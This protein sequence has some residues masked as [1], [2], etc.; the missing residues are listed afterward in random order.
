MKLKYLTDFVNIC[1]RF[2]NMNNNIYFDNLV[3]VIVVII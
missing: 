3:H 1:Y 2:F